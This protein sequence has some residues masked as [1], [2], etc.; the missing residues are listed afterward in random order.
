MSTQQAE[1]GRVVGK[2]RGSL[3][4]ESHLKKEGSLFS[5]EK[6]KEFGTECLN[7]SLCVLKS[8][9]RHRC[10]FLS[11]LPEGTTRSDLPSHDERR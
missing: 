4:K 8:G 3:Q 1:M 2:K 10:S 7:L 9:C 5:G 6:V 11:W